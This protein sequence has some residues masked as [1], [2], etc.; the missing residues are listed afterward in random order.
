MMAADPRPTAAP[1]YGQ[2]CSR[3]TRRGN[4]R[5]AVSGATVT[6][7]VSYTAP[8]SNP[9]QDEA[10]HDVTNGR[11]TGAR[12]LDPGTNRRWEISYPSRLTCRAGKKAALDDR[13]PA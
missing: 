5:V 1:C 4:N 13:I 10:G 9:L 6:L 11:V 7:T 2:R 8:S 12:R 3:W